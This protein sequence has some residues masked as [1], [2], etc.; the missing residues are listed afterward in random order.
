MAKAKSVFVCS[1]CGYE[2]PKWMGKCPSCGSWNTFYEEKLEATSSSGN[3]VKLRKSEKPRKLNSVEG[4]DEIRT[5]TGYEEVDRVLGGGLVKGS[6]VLLGGEP[7]IGKS[8]L[9]L[10]LCNKL[11]GSYNKSDSNGN[12]IAESDNKLASEGNKTA[13]E[14]DKTAG[15]ENRGIV[16]YVSGEES[17]EQV[18]LRADR[19]NIDNDNIMFLGETDIDAIETQIL[20]I[21]PKLVIIDSI[22]TMFSNEITSAP[23]TVSQVR[24]ITAR[25]MKCCKQNQITTIIIGH[26]TKDG[27]IAGP[28]ILEHMVDTV[29]YLEGERYFSYRILRSVK[30]RFGSTNEI[31]MF[32]MKNEGMC[33]VTNPSSVLISEDSEEVPGA[34]IVC[35]LEG[36]RPLLVELQALTTTSIYG[37]P[38]RTGNGIDFN[39]IALLIAVLEK[40]A[41]MNL[42]NQDV[43]LNVVSGM[44]INEPA[45]D[46]GIAAVIASSFKSVYIPK[47]TA[48]IGEVGLTGEIRAVNMIDK[49][50]KE[51]QRLGI[52]RIIIPQNNMKLLKESYKLDIIGVKNINEALRA[53]GM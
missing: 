40:R 43:Y 49:R 29:L 42:G 53:L 12:K 17:A 19:L 11:A 4:R 9:I 2:A 5:K 20:D 41:R 8:T 14:G 10:Q 7:G 22:Q 6:L 27:N 25:I 50:L 15:D 36:T 44:K 34:C 46:L 38:K 16:L 13:S 33:E 37:I 51:A 24:E 18:K 45:I 48:I 3:V 30:N 26:V 47:N 32:E 23:G 1:E 21:K 35:S 52:K 28:R 39:K 31:G